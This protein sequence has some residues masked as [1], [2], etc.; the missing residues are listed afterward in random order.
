MTFVKATVDPKTWESTGNRH[1]YKGHQIFY[2]K[3]GSG[4]A[5]LCIHGFPTA[6]W[7]WHTM[8]P[9]LARQ[10]LVIA[11]D[12]IGFGFSDKPKKYRYSISDQAELILSLLKKEN[13]HQVHILAHDY[14]DTVAQELLARF[15]AEKNQKGKM[16]IKSICFLNGGLFPE[17]HQPLLIQRLFMSP[18]GQLVGKMMSRKKL[19]KNLRAIIGSASVF[20]DEVIDDLWYLIQRNDGAAVAHLLIKYMKERVTNRARWVGAMIKTEVP[21]ALINGVDDPISGKHMVQ[22]YIELIPD[23][24]VF[25]LPGIGHFPPLED[26]EN[27]LKYYLKFLGLIDR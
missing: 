4:Q 2:K 18:V 27:V 26:H 20:P 10:Y 15:E 5:V 25:E 3:E 24:K 8:W 7:D 22:R 1:N 9:E 14:G 11:P 12:M 21:L 6:S 19:A 23:P 13:I 16:T 17:T